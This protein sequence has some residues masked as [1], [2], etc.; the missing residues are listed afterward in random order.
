MAVS[1][2]R[3]VDATTNSLEHIEA[4][5]RNEHYADWDREGRLLFISEVQ[6]LAPDQLYAL[7]DDMTIKLEGLRK[8]LETEQAKLGLCDKSFPMQAKKSGIIIAKINRSI[9]STKCFIKDAQRR[10]NQVNSQLGK[11]PGYRDFNWVQGK[12]E[13]F[14]RKALMRKLVEVLGKDQ[15][16]A[17]SERARLNSAMDFKNWAESAAIDAGW[18]KRI[19]DSEEAEAR[20]ARNRAAQ[21]SPTRPQPLALG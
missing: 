19:L 4:R 12:R 16:D 6:S 10:L 20:R 3:R 15:V 17:Y 18:I 9:Q 1:T 2:W 11:N 7:I 21:A 14:K 13:Y 5:K 8:A